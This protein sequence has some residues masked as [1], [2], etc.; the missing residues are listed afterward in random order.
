MQDIK[1]C[2]WKYVC[3]VYFRA[4]NNEINYSWVD[5]YCSVN[6]NDCVRY[7]MEEKGEPHSDKML[8]D[9]RIA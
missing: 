3:P 4:K 6:N 1:E 8:P 7:Q 9:G 2:K 5:N